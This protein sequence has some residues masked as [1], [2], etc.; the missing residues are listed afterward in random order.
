[1]TAYSNQIVKQLTW[2]TFITA[3]LLFSPF[4]GAAV[5]SISVQGLLGRKAVLLVDGTRR[6]VDTGDTTPE[7]V[8]LIA[9]HG[10]TVVMEVDGQR[11]QQTMGDNLSFS[12]QFVAPQ[13]QEVLVTQNNNGLFMERYLIVLKITA[14]P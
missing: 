7:G 3:A 11:R 12:T 6:V 5:K 8:K 14:N 10:D 9:I 13:T 4:V 1:M 2:A